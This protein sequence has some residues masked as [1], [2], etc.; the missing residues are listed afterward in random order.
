[1]SESRRRSARRQK[2]GRKAAGESGRPVQTGDQVVI[3]GHGSSGEVLE[4][5]GEEAVV[6]VGSARLRVDLV[7]LDRVGGPRRQQVT[8]KRTATGSGG[9]T[10]TSARMRIDLRGRRVDEAI[11]EVVR[12]V[13]EAVAAGLPSV[14][15]LHGKGTG[16]LRSAIHEYLAGRGDVAGFEEAPVEQGGAGVTVVRI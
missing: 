3:D 14:E 13:D 9:W 4:I 1:V 10:P 5:R 8:V 7:R 6:A 12:L 2:R 11:Q 15:I 16:A